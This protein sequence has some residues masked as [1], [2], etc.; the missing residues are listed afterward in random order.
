VIVF[1][2][3]SNY[4]V[5]FT[6]ISSSLLL[7]HTSIMTQWTLGLSSYTSKCN[8]RTPYTDI[9]KC[10]GLSFNYNCAMIYFLPCNLLVLTLILYSITRMSIYCFIQ[11]IRTCFSLCSIIIIMFADVCLLHDCSY[12]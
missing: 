3:L 6:N 12:V 9:N 1:L 7:D 5:L 11:S 2:K 8:L 4:Q 10:S